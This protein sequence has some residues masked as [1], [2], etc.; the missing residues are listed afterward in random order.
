MRKS[1]LGFWTLFIIPISLYSQLTGFHLYEKDGVYN[2]SP[3][4]RYDRASGFFTG[5]TGDYFFIERLKMHGEGG[6]AWAARKPDYHLRLQQSFISD[7]TEYSIAAAYFDKAD[8]RDRM[9]LPEWQNSLT[10]VVAKRDYYDWYRIKGGNFEMRTDIS[11]TLKITISGTW[12]QYRNTDVNARWS[13]FDWGAKKNNGHARFRINPE[14]PEGRDVSLGTAIELDTR[15]SPLASVSAWLIHSDYANARLLH[16]A[17][18]SDFSYQRGSLTITRQQ[19]MFGK[20]KWT[21]YGAYDGFSGNTV[22]QKDSSSS[23]T[24]GQFLYDAGG[25]G[26]LRGYGYKEFSDGNRRMLFQSEYYFNG[27]FLPQTPLTK[28]WGLGF[29]FKTFDLMLFWDIGHAW[30]AS[31]KVMY[32]VPDG[33]HWRDMR[34]SAGGG[35]AVSDWIKIQ[36]AYV[37]KDGIRT[38]RGNYGIYFQ[39][40]PK[41]K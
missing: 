22:I 15:P 31:E 16:K 7:N 19:R 41:L 21:F 32:F 12:Q 23:L 13:M 9:V 10:S 11:G 39:F 29:I 5:L 33:F 35:L 3:W 34:S 4:L 27:S 17:F 8:T 6:Y 25:L 40:T 37:L 2:V 14:I 26:S 28:I 20:Q 18:N 1:L 38:H 24:Y 30:Q 36:Y